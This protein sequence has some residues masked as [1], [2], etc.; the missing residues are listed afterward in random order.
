[1]PDV[2]FNYFLARKYAALQQQA[3]ATTSNAASTAIQATAQAGALNADTTLTGVRT[4][5]LPGE[6]A[7]QTALQ[8][9]QTR[10]TNENASI[11][12][13]ESIARIASVNAGTAGQLDQNKAFVRTNLTDST[14][15]STFDP[16]TGLYAGVAP[17]GA[18]A[19]GV[20]GFSGFRLPSATKPPRLPGETPVQYMDRTSW[21]L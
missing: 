12:R 3:D 16:V 19:G 11:V 8:G 14:R 15:A 17:A 21:G 5:L 2:D 7:A 20:S 4:K 1:M 9:A 6:S 13:P 18:G 10:L